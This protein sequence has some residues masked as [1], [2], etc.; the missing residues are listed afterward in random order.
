MRS[1]CGKYSRQPRRT[2]SHRRNTRPVLRP[3]QNLARDGLLRARGPRR[4][5]I[6]TALPFPQHHDHKDRQ[7]SVK[8][9]F[10]P[11][12]PRH[13]KTG[14]LDPAHCRHCWASLLLCQV[15]GR[16]L[17]DVKY[18]CGTAAKWGGTKNEA[19]MAVAAAAF[20]TLKMDDCLAMAPDGPSPRATISSMA[21]HGSR[22]SGIRGM[23]A[24]RTCSV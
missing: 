4:D 22:K 24:R 3:R 1:P 16:R 6:N 17:K 23:E 12:L 2:R 7:P 15:K 21:K 18:L 5:A 11:P 19:C 10:P 14:K 8:A 20:L 9:R 13:T